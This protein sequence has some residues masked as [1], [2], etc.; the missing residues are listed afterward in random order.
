MHHYSPRLLVLFLLAISG[1]TLAAL[2][3]GLVRTPPMGFNTYGTTAL[4]TQH[5][6]EQVTEALVASGLR[7]AGYEFVNIDGGWWG[8]DG[9][10]RITF[11]PSAG[12]YPGGATYQAGD[13]HVDP[14]IFPNGLKGIVDFVHAKNCKIGFYTTPENEAFQPDF[15]IQHAKLLTGL[16]VDYIKFD[17]YNNNDTAYPI[18]Q[19]FTEALLATGRPIVISINT[20]WKGRYP[21]IAHLWRTSP[22]INSS[23]DR[24][25]SNLDSVSISSPA[26]PG[27]WNDPDL[28]QVGQIS[29]PV[30]AEAH[31]TM[32]CLV[33]APLLING[34]LRRLYHHDRYILLN[35]E[36]IAIDQDPL[37]SPASKLRSTNGLEVWTRTLADGSRAVALFN[38]SAADAAIT[39]TWSDI[40]LSA[41]TAQVRDLWGHRQ[42]GGF[43]D[44]YSVNVPRHGAVA[45]KIVAGTTAPAEPA[46]TWAPLPLTPAPVA[47]LD[48]TGWIASAASSNNNPPQVALDGDNLTSWNT[49]QGLYPNQWFGLDMLA[50]RTFNRV[51][52]NGDANPPPYT[53]YGSYADPSV[54]KGKHFSILTS[55]DGATWRT[56]ANNIAAGPL[57]LTVFDFP[58]QIARYLRVVQTGSED[59]PYFQSQFF[60]SEINL[61]NR[62]IKFGDVNGD[63]S[64]TRADLDL[65]RL[66]FG[67]SSQD[68]GYDIVMDLNGDGR[69]DAIDLGLVI[70]NIGR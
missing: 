18:Y 60:I 35:T 45:L 69:I 44:A 12:T 68:T 11:W 24:W 4:P 61:L 46:A 63:G 2:D 62:A 37:G 51:V 21:A 5:Q 10:V 8:D 41:G 70:R 9:G 67:L 48:R 1:S 40:G 22:D 3:N 47:A 26:G 52:I 66:H 32:W 38:R 6:L 27:G 23:W 34:D 7:A 53:L 49:A 56:A 43:V 33:A 25:T 19:A 14:V 58:S 30:E 29:D 31:F 13:Y 36:L 65:V 17:G 54:T 55:D 59:S 28:L 16:G 50:P 15:P 64:V 39:V 57:G 42:L 20:G